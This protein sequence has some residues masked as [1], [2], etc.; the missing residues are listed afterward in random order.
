MYTKWF[1]NNILIR[2]S[3]GVRW[4]IAW[5]SSMHDCYNIENFTFPPHRRLVLVWIK[6][7]RWRLQLER[8]PWAAGKWVR[9]KSAF[10]TVNQVKLQVCT[11]YIAI[12][13]EVAAFDFW[14]GSIFKPHLCTVTVLL[15]NVK[16][17][18]GKLRMVSWRRKDLITY[19]KMIAQQGEDKNREHFLTYINEALNYKFK[20]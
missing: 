5:I 6:A 7:R 11:D 1:G 3:V 8:E 16:V 14:G 2:Q 19:F 17:H 15:G 4:C 13:H 20:P 10:W 12:S 9:T 18:V